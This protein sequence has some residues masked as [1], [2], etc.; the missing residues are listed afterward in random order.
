MSLCDLFGYA[1]SDEGEWPFPALPSPVH[2][3]TGGTCAGAA[4]K[5]CQGPGK[6]A[7]AVLSPLHYNVAAAARPPAPSSHGA[8]KGRVLGDLQLPVEPQVRCIRKYCK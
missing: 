2:S 4:G 6:R 3:A 8:L 1:G 7:A 5:A